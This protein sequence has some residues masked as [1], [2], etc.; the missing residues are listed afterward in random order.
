MFLWQI[1]REM[2][3]KKFNSTMYCHVCEKPFAPND[4]QVRDHCYLTGGV[5]AR[6]QIV[7]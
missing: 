5:E 1:L 4:M 2:I 7:T 3:G 6:I